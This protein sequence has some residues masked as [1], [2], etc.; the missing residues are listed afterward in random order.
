[1]FFLP[2]EAAIENLIFH[3]EQISNKM[4]FLLEK[5]VMLSVYEVELQ[6]KFIG[7]TFSFST[8][9]YT[10]WFQNLSVKVK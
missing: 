3:W 10:Y 7:I 8:S 4:N 9:K 5:W 6:N 1:M 2:K